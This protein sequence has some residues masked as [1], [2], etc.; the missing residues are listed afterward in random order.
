MFCEAFLDHHVQINIFFSSF[1]RGIF[2]EFCK[3]LIQ[4]K[5]VT[6]TSLK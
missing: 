1:H 5:C 3:V 4:R 6:G 2:Y